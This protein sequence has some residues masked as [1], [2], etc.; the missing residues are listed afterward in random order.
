MEIFKNYAKEWIPTFVMSNFTKEIWIFDFFAGTGYDLNGIVD[1][2]IHILQQMPE[3]KHN[4]P[5][6]FA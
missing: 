4:N 3:I 1:S 2:P 6:L 5:L